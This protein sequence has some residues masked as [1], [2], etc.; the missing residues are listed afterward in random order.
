MSLALSLFT[1]LGTDKRLTLCY[2][3]V[4]TLVTGH[5]SKTLSLAVLKQRPLQWCVCVRARYTHIC[6]F[7][8]TAA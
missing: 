8:S 7:Y 6:L 5:K 1:S 4:N 3:T 2:N